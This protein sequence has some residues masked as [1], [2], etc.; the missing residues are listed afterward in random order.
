MRL[1]NKQLDELAFHLPH[2]KAWVKA[3]EDELLKAL[4]EGV[5]F[6]NVGLEPKQARRRW[7]EVMED[8]TPFDVLKFLRKFSRLD[9]VA[10]RVPLSPSEAEKTLGK[11]VYKDKCAEY[12]VKQSS[13]M[14]LAYSHP[15]TEKD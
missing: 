4:E 7:I 10:P 15:E 14:K 5:Q 1:T 6:S 9:V 8:G 13:G 3:V 11:L 12:V 2:V